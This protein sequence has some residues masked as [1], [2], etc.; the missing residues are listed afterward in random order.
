MAERKEKLLLFKNL[1]LAQLTEYCDFFAASELEEL[2]I[3]EDDLKLHLKSS[4]AAAPP[5]PPP[6]A[7]QAPTQAAASST[8][9]PEVTTVAAEII[10]PA[11][12][13]GTFYAAAAPDVPP[14]VE[15]GAHVTKGMKVC[16]LE[17][18]KIMNEIE[19]P[20]VGKLIKILV[21]NGEAVTKGQPLMRLE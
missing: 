14:Y 4:T 5:S 20:V 18:M 3:E 17:A 13:T 8:Q 15:V 9:S 16:I 21:K 1:T 11:P 10:V 2:S 6:V 19:S 7:I 12:I